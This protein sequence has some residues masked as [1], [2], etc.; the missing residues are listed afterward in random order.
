M[1][2]DASNKTIYIVVDNHVRGGVE[3][4]VRTLLRGLLNHGVTTVLFLNKNYPGLDEL[5][6]LQ[7]PVLRIETYRSI[8]GSQWFTGIGRSRTPRG[9]KIHNRL[10]W[11]GEFLLTPASAAY[12]RLRFRALTNDT[13]LIVNGGYPGSPYCRAVALALGASN[14]VFM[15]VHG[16][17]AVPHRL[18]RRAEQRRDRRMSN[19][20][21]GFITVSNVAALAL[22]SRLARSGSKIFV[23]LNAVEPALHS[24]NPISATNESSRT[25]PRVQIGLVGTLHRDKG[26]FFALEVLAEIRKRSLAQDFRLVFCGSDPYGITSELDQRVRELG[27]QGLVENRGF[28]SDPTL[29]YRDLDLVLIPSLAAESFSL[30]AAEAAARAIPVVASNI[31]ALPETLHTIKLSKVLDTWEPST[32]AETVIGF[33]IDP[34][35]PE[36]LD[37]PWFSKRLFSPDMMAREYLDIL[38]GKRSS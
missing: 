35:L 12:C 9:Q 29:V 31:G 20:L 2:P 34:P 16:V 11:C 24:T 5:V 15:N 3:S 4:F 36:S 22:R 1:V 6:C 7:S 33:V 14:S 23:V 37:A 26:H 25:V 18:T 38:F 32:W 17:A 10:V 8:L 28:N 30:V 21:A 19:R 27:L 13:I